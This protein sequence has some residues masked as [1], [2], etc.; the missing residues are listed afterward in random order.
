MATRSMN[1]EMLPF[2]TEVAEYLEDNPNAYVL[3]KVT[4]IYHGNDLVARGILYE[5]SSVADH[6]QNIHYNI[7]FY[8][9]QS[10][11]EIDYETGYITKTP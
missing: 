6:G 10:G 1:L 4:P 11:A 8:N 5:A 2:E 7:Y 3:Y 9:N